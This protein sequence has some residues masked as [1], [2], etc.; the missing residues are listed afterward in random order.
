MD[1]KTHRTGLEGYYAVDEKNRKLLFE[2]FLKDISDESIDYDE[3]V[4]RSVGFVS[5]DISTLVNRAAILTAQ[6]DKDKISMDAL[7]TA[8]EKSKG[9]LP[10]VSAN[11]LKQHEQ[12]RMEF[13][14]GKNNERQRIGFM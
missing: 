14:G 8:L 2:L 4:K 6:A 1:K 13:E 3:L 10:S 7:I 12:I 11:I 9:E 5:K